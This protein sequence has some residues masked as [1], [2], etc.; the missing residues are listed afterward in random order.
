MVP[1]VPPELPGVMSCEAVPGWCAAS[2]GGLT[3][4]PVFE[5][6][7]MVEPIPEVEPLEPIP[8]VEPLEPIPEVE[9][10]EPIG[11]ALLLAPEL[12]PVESASA[13]PPIVPHA[14]NDA[15]TATR[16]IHLDI[17]I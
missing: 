13:P 14:D 7:G 2:L 4:V 17:D 6:A 15:A 8:E 3:V 9:P 12:E 5:G 1:V 10:L 16:A 11:S